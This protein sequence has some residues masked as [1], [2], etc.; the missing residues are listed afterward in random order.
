MELGVKLEFNGFMPQSTKFIKEKNGYWV[1]PLSTPLMQGELEMQPIIRDLKAP[2][3][4][5]PISIVSP[6]KNSF[7]EKACRIRWGSLGRKE[8]ELQTSKRVAYSVQ[9]LNDGFTALNIK[10]NLKQL[11]ECMDIVEKKNV[12]QTEEHVRYLSDGSLNYLVCCLLREIALKNSD[13]DIR[14]RLVKK[15]SSGCGLSLKNTIL[16][17]HWH[18]NELAVKDLGQSETSLDEGRRKI[19]DEVRYAGLW[20]NG[21]VVFFSSAIVIASNVS[22]SPTDT[23]SGD[24]PKRE[25]IVFKDNFKTIFYNGESYTYY[26]RRTNAVNLFQKIFENH[27]AGQETDYNKAAKKLFVAPGKHPSKVLIHNRKTLDDKSK[28]LLYKIL[29]WRNG[30]NSGEWIVR[31]NDSFDYTEG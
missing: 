28:D 22:E 2:T 8:S 5:N 26:I 13:W 15:F 9:F 24:V 3:K 14:E 30:K 25:I 21:S 4:S 16:Q 27:Q 7:V 10:I 1:I 18:N 29:R 11:K 17:R 6:Y 23:H 31:L 20:R 19:L 12:P